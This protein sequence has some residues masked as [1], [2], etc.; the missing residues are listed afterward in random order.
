[1]G[2]NELDL[3]IPISR[4]L[5]ALRFLDG[6]YLDLDTHFCGVAIQTCDTWQTTTHEI[7]TEKPDLLPNLPVV[8][9]AVTQRSSASYS[10]HFLKDDL[11]LDW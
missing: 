6:K 4:V 7:W 10:H 1:M 11:Y 8:E 2:I 5:P 3:P 9:L